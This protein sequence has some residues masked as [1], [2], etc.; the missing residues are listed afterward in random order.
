MFEYNLICRH[1]LGFEI[2]NGLLDFYSPYWPARIKSPIWYEIFLKQTTTVIL[3]A[4][5]TMGSIIG[6]IY[7]SQLLQKLPN[8]IGLERSRAHGVFS[9]DPE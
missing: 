7:I 1:D 9:L 4:E 6:Y 2:K 3:N 8:Q 5:V